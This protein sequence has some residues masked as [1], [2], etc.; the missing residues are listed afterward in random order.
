MQNN[1]NKAP[2]NETIK[3]SNAAHADYLSNQ[4]TEEEKQF[5]SID[6]YVEGKKER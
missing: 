4:L 1:E 3:K 2:I 6:F 5:K